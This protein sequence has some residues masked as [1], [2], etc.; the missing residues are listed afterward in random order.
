LKPREATF[1]DV[2]VQTPIGAVD[3]DACIH[4]GKHTTSTEPAGRRFTSVPALVV[5]C[6]MDSLRRRPLCGRPGEPGFRVL[7]TRAGADLSHK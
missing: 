2:V 3:R 4:A 1:G 6:R 5:I 7:Y